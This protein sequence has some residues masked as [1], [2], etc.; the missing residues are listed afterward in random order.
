MEQ[1]G[2]NKRLLNSFSETVEGEE[3][4]QQQQQEEEYP[5]SEEDDDDEEA[6]L[7]RKSSRLARSVLF[8][9]TDAE[10]CFL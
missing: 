1:C 7:L 10:R 2:L 9:V 5:D 4:D 3:K 6:S 8:W